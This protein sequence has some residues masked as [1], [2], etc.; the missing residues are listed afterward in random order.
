MICYQGYIHD[1]L[2]MPEQP[3]LFLEEKNE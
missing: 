1:A 3:I 2:G